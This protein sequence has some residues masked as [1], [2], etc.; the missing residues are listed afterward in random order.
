MHARILLWLAEIVGERDADTA[1][2]ASLH[3]DVTREDVCAIERH[4]YHGGWTS[5]AGATV[6]C[7]V[8][9]QR[10]MSIFHCSTR[11]RLRC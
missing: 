4:A 8:H 7:S 1:R 9:A 6:S 2:C 3:R 5:A 11:T 10:C